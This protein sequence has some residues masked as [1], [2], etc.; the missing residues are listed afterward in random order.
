M[1]DNGLVSTTKQALQLYVQIFGQPDST[2]QLQGIIGS[3]LTVQQQIGAMSLSTDD[4][5][6]VT[7][8]LTQHFQEIRS[9]EHV[10]EASQQTLVQAAHQRLQVLTT[11]AKGVLTAYVQNFAPS[12][13]TT[14]IQETVV[15]LLPIL[16]DGQ[17]NR[18]E[19]SALIED[20][21]QHFQL[22]NA[23]AAVIEPVYLDLA[24]QLAQAI[25]QKPLEEAVEA[26]IA[27]YLEKYE[28]SL[29]ILGEGLIEHAIEA[30]T[31]SRIEFN[32]D[33]ELNLENRQLLIKQVAF[34]L[35]I[36]KASP[37]ASKTARQFA[38]QI[39]QAIE[40]FQVKRAETLGTP[41]DITGTSNNDNLSIS[42]SW[43]FAESQPGGNDT[44][45]Q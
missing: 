6:A 16:E 14:E 33:T 31:R 42:S 3:L 10:L 40:S 29:E 19:A 39:N 34:K 43:D 27:A 13:A 32:W 38:D 24:Q 5:A 44:G 28:P 45:S 37:P 1:V 9:V 20:I 4:I 18:G 2:N 21:S 12:I 35:N 25:R 11:Q 30:V 15:A 8:Q 26:T 23:L 41:T 17:I 22:Q 36:M 7:Q